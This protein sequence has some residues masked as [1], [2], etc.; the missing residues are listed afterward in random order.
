MPRRIVIKGT[1][2][3]GKSTLGAE[4]AARLGVPFIELDDLHHG[5]NWTAP[6]NEEFIAKVSAAMA[7]CPNGWV[8]DGNYDSK[9]GDTVTGAAD[10]IL[11]LDLPLSLKL[12]R[13]WRRTNHRIRHKVEL[14]AGNRETWRDAYLSRQSLFLWLIE[15]HFRHHR[16]W[17]TRY[18][19]DSRFVRLR[20]TEEIRRWL[21]TQT[22]EP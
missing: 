9:L 6:T 2:A 14:W 18:G 3:A 8:I 5:S 19:G 12:R 17:P 20:T 7:A 1:S 21:E 13:L 11:W 15:T 22:P 4:L 10:T 16:E